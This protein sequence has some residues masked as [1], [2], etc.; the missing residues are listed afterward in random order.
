MWHWHTLIRGE[1]LVGRHFN[2]P[3]DA[4]YGS[5]Y[6]HYKVPLEDPF[7]VNEQPSS[8]RT[9][10]VSELSSD[11]KPRPIPKT[12]VRQIHNILKLYPKGLHITELC[13]ELGKSCI[14]MDKDF[15]GY[16]KFSRFL[17]SMPDIL[18]LK[19]HDDGQFIVH[20]VT[21]KWPKEPLES[22]RGTSGNGTEEQDTNLIAKLNNNG[23]STDSTCVPVLPSNAQ[24]KPLKVKP[25]SEY[26]KHISL[27]MEG[28]ASRCP[29]L[30]PPV[31]EDS[32]QTS[33][34]EA[35]SN[36]TPSI[37][38][39]SKAKMSFFSRIWRRLLGNNDTN[40][41][42]GSHCIS[43]KCSTS[44]D[45]SKQKSCSGLVATYSGD[46]PREAK[47][48][49]RTTMPMSE[50][51]NSV[52]QVSN[53]PDLESAKLQKTVMVA[54]AH[55]DKSS[56]DLELFGS[57]RNWFKF[58]AKK[59]ENGEV[60]EHCCEQNQLKNQSGKHHLF[61]SNS[62]WQ[63][64]QSFMETPKGV[65]VISR[66]KTRS[67]IAQNLLEGGPPVLKSLSTSD[68]FD[69]LELLISDKK[70]VEEFPSET[71]PFKLTLS[72]ARKNSSM[73][74]LHHANGLTSIFVNKESQCSFQGSREHDSDSDKKNENISQATTMTKNKFPDRT[75]FEI[76][77]DC[78]KLVD[79]I[80]RD[81]PEGYNIGAFGSLFLEKY[82]YHLDWQKLGYPK[83]ASLLQ[84]IPGVT[85]AST[86]IIPTSKAP[87]VS[88]L[89]TALLS[90]SEKNTFDAIANSDNESSD[91]PRKDGDFESAWEELGPICTDCS[92][93]N[94]AELALNSETIE[95]TEK[96]QKVYY[97]PL[98]S[99]DESME[100]DGE[101]CPATEVPA[102]QR[103][104]EE[105]SSLIQ[106]LD[107]W[108]SSQE[109]SKNDKT[110][111][112]YETVDCSENSSK[113]SSLVP[114]S[115][116]NT[117]SFSRKQRHQKD[118]S[119]VTDTDE[120]DKEKLIDGILGTLKKLS[121]SADT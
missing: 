54:I 93:E 72:I 111:N 91:L 51:A 83:L 59:T 21:P 12:V 11:S 32:K 43:E 109:D 114:K 47:T 10:E 80:L 22:S 57:I 71:N 18:K 70:W 118:Y 16:K 2:Q 25:S 94:K 62:F 90:D 98:L 61:S 121:K 96:I 55:D 86:F 37:E 26:G 8:L 53:S 95:A 101:S 34:F 105:E 48:E 4:L 117:G 120:N 17:L 115:E 113:L 39:H 66:S 73:E 116:V 42:N 3:P 81:H 6:G 100:T 92:S 50:D 44:D 24:D 69:F 15:Y 36:M 112:S 103:A 45:T 119:F 30:E 99:E 78:Q 28:E 52:H 31:I 64:M 82:G 67:E 40:S 65:E 33:K 89:E 102:K 5:W 68:L 29:V 1:N 19:K 97:E 9:E 60:S 41:K 104:N 77:G 87:K 56:S 74:S 20:M 88:K 58:W 49:G 106:I 84:I 38:Q 76:L 79:E 23:S 85:I 108:Y 14:S 75:R 46:S 110:E 107:S 13:S 7:P 35:D 63:D 27:A